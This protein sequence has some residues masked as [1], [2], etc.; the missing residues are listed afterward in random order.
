MVKSPLDTTIYAP[1]LKRLEIEKHKPDEIMERISNFVEEIRLQT[2]DHSAS[3]N[4]FIMS[5]KNISGDKEGNVD[6]AKEQDKETNGNLEETNL[7]VARRIVADAEN[8]KATVKPPPKGNGFLD[9]IPRGEDH[10]DDDDYFY[11]VCHVDSGLKA[12][13][14]KGEYIDLERLLPKKRNSRGGR[15]ISNG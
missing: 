10:M 11:L 15:T 9:K 7:E 6:G 14:E 2:V 13:I 4:K 8:F 3:L 12:K 1:A 5:D